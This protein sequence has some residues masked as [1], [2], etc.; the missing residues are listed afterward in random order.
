MLI[1]GSAR[2]TGRGSHQAA[3]PNS[4]MIAGTARQR[5][6]VASIAIATASPTPNCLTIAL[7]LSTKLAKTNTMISA[8]EVITRPVVARPS[9]TA[10][11]GSPSSL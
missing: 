10:L 3:L 1:R 11:C 9:T 2:S 5:T 6:T 7:P 8:A 4:A